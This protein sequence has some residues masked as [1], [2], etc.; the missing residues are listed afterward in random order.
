MLSFRRVG[1]TYAGFP[2][3]RYN[4]TLQSAPAQNPNVPPPPLETKKPAARQEPSVSAS[5]PVQ[6]EEKIDKRASRGRRFPSKRPHITLEHPRQY[7]RPVAAGALP[8]YDYALEYIKRDSKLRKQEL[9]EYRTLL[10]KAESTPDW[11]PEDL[12][13]LKEK[14][15]ILEVQSEI[16]LPSV[17]WKARNGMG[18]YS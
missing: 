5:E 2:R 1:R 8:V 18:E 10:Q 11:N 6:P 13:R 4:A 12:E 3:V 15:H 16:N 7:N 14:I 17:R 9:E